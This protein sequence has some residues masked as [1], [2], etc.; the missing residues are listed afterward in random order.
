MLP[1]MAAG[2][3][4]AGGGMIADAIGQGSA[5]RALQQDVNNY[6][7][8][9]ALARAQAMER[10]NKLREASDKERN[11]TLDYLSADSQKA[12]Q[13]QEETRLGQL[14]NSGSLGTEGYKLSGQN[15]G[16]DNFQAELARRLSNAADQTRQRI[17]AL[18]TMSSYGNSFN[19]LGTN[20]PLEL[21][22][23]GAIID[24]NN[25][26]RRNNL[27]AYQQWQNVPQPDRVYQP[28]FLSTAAKQVGGAMLGSGMAELGAS[29]AMPG[30]MLSPF[31]T[32]Y[33]KP[34]PQSGWFN[35]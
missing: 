10:D 27:Y 8:V 2:A 21:Q 6:N 24:M 9:Q 28:G 16:G 12:R 14:Y 31:P 18:A 13:G 7:M 29:A 1:M 4:L 25:Q 30:G 19:G 5:N 22:R 35:F 11:V 33:S 34:V 26:M 3:A 23:S 20:N 17:G 32:S 15:F